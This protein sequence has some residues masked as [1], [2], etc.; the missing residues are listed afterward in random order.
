MSRPARRAPADRLVVLD[1]RPRAPGQGCLGGAGPADPELL[2]LKALK[3]LAK[4]DV[5]VHD[6]LVSAEILELAPRGARRI[7]VAQRKSRHTL[8][9]DEINRLLVAFA[10]AGPSG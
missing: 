8:P 7:N 1:G 9:Q 10:L 4:A 3:A 2:T 5:V 6:G